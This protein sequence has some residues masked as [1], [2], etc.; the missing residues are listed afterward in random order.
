[1]KPSGDMLNHPASDLLMQYATKGCPVNC[2]QNWSKEDIEAA[3][4]RGPHQSALE[5]DAI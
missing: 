3:I 5:P 4:L 2:G 1:M